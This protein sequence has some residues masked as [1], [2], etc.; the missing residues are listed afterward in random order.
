[1]NGEEARNKWLEKNTEVI[2]IRLRKVI[3]R[4]TTKIEKAV[5][6]GKGYITL[7]C[8]FPFWWAFLGYNEQKIILNYLEGLGFELGRYG[9]GVS[10]SWMPQNVKFQEQFKIVDVSERLRH[11]L[12][13]GHAPQVTISDQSE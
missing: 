5:D 3:E 8:F 11:V 7:G 10:V 4:I 13:T 2:A 9:D 12:E 6:K 1:M